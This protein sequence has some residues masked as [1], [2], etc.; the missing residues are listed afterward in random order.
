M[1]IVKSFL[2]LLL[3]LVAVPS[4]AQTAEEIINNYIENTGGMDAWMNIKGMK[5]TG[6][7]MMGGQT[8]PFEQ[9][10]MSDGR[11]AVVID[12][13]GQRFTP[14]AFDGKQLWST[15]FQSMQAEAADK[16]AS[17]NYIKNEAQDFPDPFLNYKENG[18]TVELAGEETV[19]GTE[20]YKLILTKNPIMV[21]GEAKP[22]VNTYFFD[23]ENFVPIV[24]ESTINQ[25]PR[26][27]MTTQTVYSEY[28]Q[29][30]DVYIPFSI[31]QKFNGQVGQTIKIKDIEMNPEVDDSLFQMPAPAEADEEKN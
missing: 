6:D 12:L 11:M 22:N 9:S 2:I 15:N 3:V 28:M 7:A 8:F 13:Q 4:N 17:E 23:K 20:C 10:M 19:E 5:T 29:A 30:G 24:M 31:T 25:G 21:D 1:K 14:Q 26:A 27:G 18:Y 16:E